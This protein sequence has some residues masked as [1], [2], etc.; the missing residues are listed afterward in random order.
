MS[1]PPTALAPFCEMPVPLRPRR[2]GRSPGAFRLRVA[3]QARPESGEG[4]V[5]VPCASSSRPPSS[6]SGD[7][8]TAR[9]ASGG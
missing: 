3:A 8:A 2:V 5:T 7:V 1:S 4:V 9:A 6:C